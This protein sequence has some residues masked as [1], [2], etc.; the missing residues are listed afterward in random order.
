MWSCYILDE[1]VSA[2]VDENLA[3]TFDTPSIVLPCQE[4]D[5]LLQKHGDLA[6]LEL[7]SG[8][9][10]AGVVDIGLRAHIVRVSYLRSQTLR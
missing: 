6:S 10:N 9:T 2:G 8:L 3:W 4:T 1:M 5:F 7:D